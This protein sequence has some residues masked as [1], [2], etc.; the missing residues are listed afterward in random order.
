M[1]IVPLFVILLSKYVESFPKQRLVSFLGNGCFPNI[2]LLPLIIVIIVILSHVCDDSKKRI[3]SNYPRLT[4]LLYLLGIFVLVQADW[5]SL[6]VFGIMLFPHAGLLLSNPYV[7][8]L[9]FFEE[10]PFGLLIIPLMDLLVFKWIIQKYLG[11]IRNGKE[12][13]LCKVITTPRKYMMIST[14]GLS[15]LF[16]VLTITC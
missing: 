13:L 2:L 1:W 10:Y 11:E 14:L 4:F 8:Q 12:C 5:A 9:Q 16:V 7:D 15:M 6:S 3:R